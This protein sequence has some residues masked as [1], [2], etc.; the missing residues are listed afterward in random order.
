MR[1][2][3]DSPVIHRWSHKGR[4]TTLLDT[5]GFFPGIIIVCLCNDYGIDLQMSVVQFRRDR[6]AVGY[7]A[8]N[9]KLY[10]LACHGERLID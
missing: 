9:V 4:L 7:K 6:F 8:L 1:I 10:S 2:H 5:N 3:D